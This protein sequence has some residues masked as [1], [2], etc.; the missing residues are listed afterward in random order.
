MASPVVRAGISSVA[1]RTVCVSSTVV[2]SS[3]SDETYHTTRPAAASANTTAMMMAMVL[4]RTEAPFHSCPTH[5]S[6]PRYIGRSPGFLHSVT[7][8]LV[9]TVDDVRALSLQE[10]R[11][12]VSLRRRASLACSQSLPVLQIRGEGAL[13]T[14]LELVGQDSRVAQGPYSIRVT[15]TGGNTPP[16]M[17]NT[18]RTVKCSAGSSPSGS[19][20]SKVH[21]RRTSWLGSTMSLFFKL[22]RG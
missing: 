12:A 8:R 9:G 17:S 7:V 18:P 1:T 11:T 2:V 21:S 3:L 15:C 19:N 4:R 5:Y 14:A 13:C 22:L 10:Q 20:S 16:P 6:N